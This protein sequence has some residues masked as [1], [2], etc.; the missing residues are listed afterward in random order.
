MAGPSYDQWAEAQALDTRFNPS[1]TEEQRT[2]Q[3]SFA[4]DP[5]AYEQA[6]LSYDFTNPSAAGPMT[7]RDA[8]QAMVN[9]PASYEEVD[10][11]TG[12]STGRKMKVKKGRWGNAIVTPE[13]EPSVLAGPEGLTALPTY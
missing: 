1:M 2:R 5:H 6:Q 3:L 10:L 8:F 7:A 13:G 9:R 4:M 11:K 12:K